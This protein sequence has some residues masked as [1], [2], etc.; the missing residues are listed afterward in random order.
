MHDLSVVVLQRLLWPFTLLCLLWLAYFFE[1]ETHMKILITLCELYYMYLILFKNIR[2]RQVKK[3]C[4]ILIIA[5]MLAK[6]RYS[7]DFLGRL[8]VCASVI[9][10]KYN[11]TGHIDFRLSGLRR[12]LRYFIQNPLYFTCIEVM[13]PK[14]CQCI[15]LMWLTAMI[16]WL[17]I[18][19]LTFMFEWNQFRSRFQNVLSKLAILIIQVLIMVF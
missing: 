9:W 2:D 11:E 19:E 5:L 1:Y 3:V 12:L 16:G 17:S 6:F 8:A 15:N 18:N 4:K 13:F 14:A 7:S 10:A